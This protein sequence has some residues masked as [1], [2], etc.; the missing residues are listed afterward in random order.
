MASIRKRGENSYQIIVSNGYDSNKKKLTETKTI[1]VDPKLTPRQLE[2]ELEKQAALFEHEVESGTYLDGNKMTLKEFSER[3]IKDHAEKQNAPRTLHS[4][5]D[6]LD[7]RIIPAL[8]HIAMG[9]LQPVHLIEFYNNLAEEGMRRDI[10]YKAKPELIET[11]KE[12]GI[13]AFSREVDLSFKTISSLCKNGNTTI[14]IVEKISKHFEEKPGNL[15]TPLNGKGKLA[16][17]TMLRCHAV[18]SSMLNDAVHWQVIASNP[19]ARV[20]PPKAEHKEACYYDEEQTEYMLKCLEKEDIRVKTAVMLVVFGGMRLGEL[21]G[22]EWKY[23]DLENKAI[24]IVKASQYDNDPEKPKNEHIYEKQ[25]KN[26]TSIRRI[27]ISG[28]LIKTL[29]KYKVWQNEERLKLD[30]I[31]VESDRLFTKWNGAPI[32]P[33][34]ISAWFSKFRKKYNLPPLTFHQLRHTN[35]SLMI[36]QGVDVA[37]VSKRLGHANINTTLSIYSHALKRPDREA[38]DKLDTLFTKKARTKKA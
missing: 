28:L 20:E 23:A 17:S 30:G 13:T 4:C 25:P 22:L 1:T 27:T 11:M 26:R 36:A 12:K 34:T 10:H 33:G 8:G 9:K 31:W 29:K 14:K 32:F 6:A 35:A 37:T 24:Q 3:W 18:L 19:T 5:K 7:N 2:K 21:A 38:A 16:G 15:F